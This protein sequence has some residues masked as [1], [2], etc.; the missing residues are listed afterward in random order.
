MRGLTIVVATADR[1]RFRS[2]IGLAAAQAAMG[3][4]ARLFLDAAAVVLLVP[5]A[6]LLEDAAHAEAG[7]PTLAEL[8]ETALVLGVTII[9][10][11]SGLALA[12]LTAGSIDPRVEYSGL[13]GLLA[14]LGEDRLAI[15]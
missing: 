9:A 10:C 2:A 14:A 8:Q 4:R 12:G 15:V 13:T 6:A 3:G 5:R 7:L 1:G 11:Q